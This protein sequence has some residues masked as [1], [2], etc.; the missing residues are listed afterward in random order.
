MIVMVMS[1]MVMVMVMAVTDFPLSHAQQA[2]WVMKLRVV[3]LYVT[4]VVF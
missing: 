3:V 2:V 1:M 4:V